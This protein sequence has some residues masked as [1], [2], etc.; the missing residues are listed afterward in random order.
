MRLCSTCS[1]FVNLDESE[2]VKALSRENWDD[3]S[4]KDDEC[5]KSAKG[6]CSF[7][8]WGLLPP[9][10]KKFTASACNLT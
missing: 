4:G 10:P 8:L 9:L 3:A 7:T 1:T 5:S 6:V 2:L